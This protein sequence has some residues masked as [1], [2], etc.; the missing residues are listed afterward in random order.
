MTQF[1]KRRRGITGHTFIKSVNKSDVGFYYHNE[2]HY[3]TRK[4]LYLF[5]DTMRIRKAAV[6]L[7][8]WKAFKLFI[9]LV[10]ISNSI[11]MSF[12][13]YGFRMD[14][15]Q[16]STTPF[17]DISAKVITSIF[18]LEFLIKVIA[19]GLVLEKHTYMRDPW[20][21]LDFVCLLTGIAE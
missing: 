10:V 21:V 2:I 19:M 6:W 18:T 20:N 15:S 13:S 11:I 17:E 5:S 3:H 14:S 9:L 16:P 7:I 4:S 1:T 8:H 12:H